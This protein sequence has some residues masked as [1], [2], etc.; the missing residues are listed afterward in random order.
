MTQ[1]G[2]MNLR[3]S[4]RTDKLCGILGTQKPFIQAPM[5]GTDTPDMVVAVTRAGGLGSLA[6][7]M[8]TPAQIHESFSYIRQHT[9]KTVNL[10]FFCHRRCEKSARQQAHWK[11]RLLPY[12]QQLGIDINSV[13]P[14]ATRV[15]FDDTFCAVVEELRPGVVSFHFG[16]PDEQLLRRVKGANN[17]V[18]SSATTAQEARWLEQHGCDIVIAQGSEAGGHRG[19]FLTDDLSSQ[20]KTADLLPEI[21]AAVSVPV[22]AAGGICDAQSIQ[23]ALR[24]GAAG[25]QVGTAYLFCKEARVAPLHRDMLKTDRPTALTNIFSGRPARGIVNRLMHEVGPMSPDAPDFPHASDYITPLRQASE[26]AGRVDFMQMWSG[27]VRKPHDMD[28]E[29]LTAFLCADL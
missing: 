8:L 22:V 18:M 7:A 24:A 17:I 16:L 21:I 14:A 6:C 26:K 10:N 2:K 5:A 4:D 27:D 15:P 3:S 1:H 13:A 9:D 12:Y 29:A 20:Q 19:M 28:A 25:V 23:Q 11:A